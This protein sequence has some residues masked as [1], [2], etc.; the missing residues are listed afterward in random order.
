TQAALL[1]ALWPLLK[2]GGKLLYATC[3]IFP[4]E[5]QLQISAFNAAFAEARLLQQ[6][7]LLPDS[8][9]DGF[10]YALLEKPLV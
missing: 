6:T 10:F 3:S 2:P 7:Q 5:N 8:Q 4:E 1:R 9:H